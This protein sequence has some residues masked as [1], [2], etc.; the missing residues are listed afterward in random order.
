VELAT[1]FGMIVCA[2]R[3]HFIGHFGDELGQELFEKTVEVAPK[4]FQNFDREDG[5]HDND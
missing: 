1:D 2:M 5:I 3:D 4:Y